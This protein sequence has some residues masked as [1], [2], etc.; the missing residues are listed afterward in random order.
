M[1][2]CLAAVL[3]LCI[4]L[5]CTGC[6]VKL[7]FPEDNVV[8]NGEYI[9]TTWEK[10]LYLLGVH[11]E[12][13]KFGNLFIV[14]K[15]IDGIAVADFF[16][17]HPFGMAEEPHVY[18]KEN[19]N[20]R[21]I[22]CTIPF[23]CNS[24]VSPL[25][26]CRT[27]TSIV[28]EEN[29]TCPWIGSST[30][31][32]QHIEFL[33]ERGASYV[34]EDNEVLRSFKGLRDAT[35]PLPE[36]HETFHYLDLEGATTLQ[37]AIEGEPTN[38]NAILVPE[39]VEVISSNYFEQVKNADIFMRAAEPKEEFKENWSGTCTVHWGFKDEI[40][41]FDS[42]GGTEIVCGATGKNYVTAKIGEVLEKPADPVKEG[43]E[44]EGWYKD[45]YFQEPW[46]FE[47]E[48]VQSSMCLYAKW[49]KI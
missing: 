8:D 35:T 15:E 49:E 18:F 40:V 42:Y 9:Y 24:K 31:N 1:K 23:R 27:I 7:Y 3:G 5:F 29:V 45:Y 38:L 19:K 10:K 22:I 25:L 41:V 26:N 39:T 43:Y 33:G 17:N 11:D 14:P 32:L 20:I 6:D 4:V 47:K 36:L 48:Q 37:P 21:H 13:L 2:K 12:A 44:F 46:D 16:V 34:L 28:Y 30:P